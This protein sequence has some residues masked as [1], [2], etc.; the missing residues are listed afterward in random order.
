MSALSRLLAGAL[1]WT[2]LATG[3]M[4]AHTLQQEPAATRVE[5]SEEETASRVKADVARRMKIEAA[6]VRTIETASRTW[7]DAGL[8]CNARRGV[9]DPT[10]VPGFRIVAEANGRQ[11]VYHTDRFGRLLRCSTPSK[12]LAPIR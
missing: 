8:G 9:L 7:P 3:P 11:F 12:P 5:L 2:M 1:G 4:A 6:A 10:P